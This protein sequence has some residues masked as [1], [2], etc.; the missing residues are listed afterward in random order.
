MCNRIRGHLALNLK[1]R[2]ACE[3]FILHRKQGHR[4]TLEKEGGWGGGG[5]GVLGSEWESATPVHDKCQECSV[6]AV[7]RIEEETIHMTNS[8]MRKCF[9]MYYFNQLGTGHGIG[10]LYSF[11]CTVRF[12]ISVHFS[13]ILC[14]YCRAGTIFQ[15]V[16]SHVP[17]VSQGLYNRRF[18]A[19]LP[20]SQKINLAEKLYLANGD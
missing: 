7:A 5:G 14:E 20:Y 6:K 8:P 2:Y 12:Q 17:Y 16:N 4:Q 15:S 3:V 18:H 11:L 13:Q 9:G 19:S 10:E 1:W